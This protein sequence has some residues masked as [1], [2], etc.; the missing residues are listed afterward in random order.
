MCRSTT[1][2]V[3]YQFLVYI[4]PAKYN[5]F[6]PDLFDTAVHNT[7]AL[8]ISVR[9]EAKFFIQKHQHDHTTGN[10]AYAFDGFYRSDK[11]VKYKSR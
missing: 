6:R 10:L 1:A 2:A 9:V 5:V 7:A 11:A 3:L 8:S 4:L